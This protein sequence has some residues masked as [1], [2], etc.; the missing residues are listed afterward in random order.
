MDAF[1]KRTRTI[2]INGHV[3]EATVLVEWEYDDNVPDFDYGS[4]ELNQAELDRFDSGELLNILVTVTAEAEGEAA[5]EAIGQVFVS[6]QTMKTDINTC[7]ED[8]GMVATACQELKTIIM[9][10]ATKLSKYITKEAL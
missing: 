9:D 3:V 6:A 2:D 8:N 4:P 5:G 10:K 7:V 1:E